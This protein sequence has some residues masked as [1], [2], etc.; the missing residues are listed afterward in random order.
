MRTV[1]EDYRIAGLVHCWRIVSEVNVPPSVDVF[2]RGLDHAR[3]TR[4]ALTAEAYAEH[5]VRS[6][7]QIP[8]PR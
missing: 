3:E 4:P 2:L 8:F 5:F 7:Q 1:P 6:Y